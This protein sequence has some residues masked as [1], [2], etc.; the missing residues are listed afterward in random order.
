VK[1]KRLIIDKIIK[2]I[3]KYIMIF[4]IVEYI[5]ACITLLLI[6]E[7]TDYKNLISLF[8]IIIFARYG[9]YLVFLLMFKSSFYSRAFPV[10]FL[11]ASIIVFCM[12]FIMT[13]L[14]LITDYRGIKSFEL[15]LSSTSFLSGIF[16]F[17]VKNNDLINKKK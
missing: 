8:I 4:L 9:S 1:D 17:K 16:R 2:F 5:S 13:S 15:V 14:D 11:W 7:N 12:C 3:D 6:D 10:F